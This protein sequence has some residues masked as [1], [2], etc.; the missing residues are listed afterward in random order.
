VGVIA[1]IWGVYWSTGVPGAAT[2]AHMFDHWEMQSLPVV[3]ARE[4]S[5]L[6]IVAAW[7]AVL[8]VHGWRRG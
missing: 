7:M 5:G 1:L 4:T 3:E 2:Y 6:F 8:A